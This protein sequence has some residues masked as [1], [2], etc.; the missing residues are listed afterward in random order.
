[1]G[2]AKQEDDPSILIQVKG[3]DVALT[4]MGMTQQEAA[5]LI[6]KVAEQFKV[7]KGMTRQ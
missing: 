2:K 7:D 6:V 3:R 4:F 5:A 1:M